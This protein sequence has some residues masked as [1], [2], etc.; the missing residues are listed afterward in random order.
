MKKL[1]SVLVFLFM[2]FAFVACKDETY[3]VTFDSKG[4]TAV[5]AVEVKKDDLVPEPTAPTKDGFEFKGWYKD[6]NY[7]SA[8]EFSED[9]VTEDI[10]LYAKWDPVK[11]TV[12]FNSKGGSAVDSVQ[13][14]KDALVPEP[15]APTRDGFE[16]VGWY[17]DA[18]Y[19]TAWDF[20][21]DKVSGNITLYAKWEPIETDTGVV[22]GEDPFAGT[23]TTGVGGV[24]VALYYDATEDDEAVALEKVTF[25]VESP[26][27]V[28]FEAEILE[29]P[30]LG[31]YY[32]RAYEPGEYVITLTV[33]DKDGNVIACPETHTITYGSGE[34]KSD[35]SNRND[36]IAA[37]QAIYPG[38]LAALPD[39][40]DSEGV[41]NEWMIVGKDFV[42]FDRAGGTTN[43]GAFF[44]PYSMFE[45]GEAL[46]NFTVSFKYT[47]INQAWKLLLSAWTGAPGD[48]LFAGDLLRVLTNRNQIG[49]WNDADS[50]SEFGDEGEAKNIPLKEGPVYIKFTREVKDGTATFKLYTSLDGETYELKIT[51]TAENVTSES[52][53]VGAN[54]TG[55]CLFSID[56]D[57]IIENLEVS[58][59]VFTLD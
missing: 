6:E 55:F 2:L 45:G 20:S 14:E 46:Q 42:V 53:N 22:F 5:A 26:E 30:K 8:W 31:G 57:F 59:T 35:M 4:G 52:G 33:E 44:V 28:E 21:K 11:Y 54:L 25:T 9:K 49:I 50:G 37:V 43:F 36:M 39:Y 7:T 18:E 17:K 16:F 13:V 41:L 10:T 38:N 34:L 51:S 24:G 58:G 23:A 15:T 3:K 48:D 32:I 29:I 40:R 56:N 47:T 12:T 1:F 19:E 27:D